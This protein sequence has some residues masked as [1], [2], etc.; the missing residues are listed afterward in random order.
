MVRVFQIAGGEW[1]ATAKFVLDPR[2]EFFV[3]VVVSIFAHAPVEQGK[4]VGLDDRSFVSPVF[5]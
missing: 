5:D 4:F 2:A 1:S 3:P